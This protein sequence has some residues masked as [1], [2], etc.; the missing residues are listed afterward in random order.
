M[1][2]RF[3]VDY[4]NK[5]EERIGTFWVH[6]HDYLEIY[7]FLNFDGEYDGS[8]FYFVD[9]T[10]Y[11]PK[12]GDVLIFRPNVM[13]GSCKKARARYDR[14]KVRLPMEL[15]EAIKLIDSRLYSF[16]M[17]GAVSLRL[18]DT[19]KER[20]F[21]L[22]DQMLV[23]MQEKSDHRDVLLFSCLLRQLAILGELSEIS[24]ASGGSKDELIIRILNTVNAEYN[25]LSSVA[26]IARRL[27]YSPNY[28]SQY[29]KK[30][31]NIGLHE[32]LNE[33]KLAVAAANLSAGM[34]V[35]KC[36]FECGVDST[37][38]FIRAFKAFYGVTPKQYSS[39][40]R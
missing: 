2:G 23:Y 31:L 1:V 21:E 38:H 22:I 35:T 29:F 28:I 36:G 13:H 9:N 33:K 5:F 11:V 34:S 27:N 39:E 19:Y 24:P 32:Y 26:D 17:D 7:T 10:I 18:T 40:K 12:V 25:T 4:N 37:S 20:Y 6:S 30:R 8:Y 14:L 16:L 15:I 3:S